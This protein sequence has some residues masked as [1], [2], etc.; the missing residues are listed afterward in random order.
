LRFIIH[1]SRS[2]DFLFQPHPKC[3]SRESGGVDKI[4]VF[5][6]LELGNRKA[7]RK[8]STGEI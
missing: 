3:E 5:E 2:L 1:K 6:L 7:T 4:R 8:Y